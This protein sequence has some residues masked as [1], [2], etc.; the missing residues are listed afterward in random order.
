MDLRFYQRRLAVSAE[1]HTAGAGACAKC[2]D[3]DG[4]WY[5][6]VRS[7]YV[8]S[9]WRNDFQPFV[10]RGLREAGYDV[11]DFRNPTEGDTGFH[12]SSIDPAWKD[13]TPAAF[14]EG[15]QHP[16]AERGFRLDLEAMERSDAVVMVQP[17][18]RSA[19]LEL[20]WFTGQGRPSAVLLQE[21]EPELMLA[22]ADELCTNMD[23]VLVWLKSAIVRRNPTNHW[24]RDRV[25]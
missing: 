5:R 6:P 24:L 25:R 12:W 1:Q 21:G 22:L 20:G 19:A 10:V 7:I 13:W 15:L 17:S 11:Y 16:I 9:S 23:E 3:L 18:G 2:G 8:A 14:R 4:C